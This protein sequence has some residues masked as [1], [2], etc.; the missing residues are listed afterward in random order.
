MKPELGS[1]YQGTVAKVCHNY[2][3]LVFPEGFTGLLHISELSNNY[4]RNFTGYVKVGNI[5]TVKVIGV[6]DGDRS[7]HVS[8]KQVANHDRKKAFRGDPI[9][10]E[11]VD[12][13][14]LERHLPEWI[15][16]KEDQQ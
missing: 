9:P 12:F 11:E 13:K 8:L 7:V 4:I 14:A 3:I 5:Y 6:D 2:A 1:I 16:Q 10:P 15:K